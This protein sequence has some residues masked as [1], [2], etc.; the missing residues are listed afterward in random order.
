MN[1]FDINVLLFPSLLIFLS[2]FWVS[3][4]VTGSIA[5]ASAISLLKAGMF[6]AYFGYFFDGTYT[7]LDDWSYLEGGGWLRSQGVGVTNLADNWGFVLMV[8][9]GE[10]FVYYLYNAYAITLFGDGYYAPVALNVIATVFIAWGGALLARREFNFGK[11]GVA[12]FLASL[13]FNP[14]FWLGRTS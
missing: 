6:L 2:A 8:G 13:S 5:A 12:L 14:I 7:F 10:H 9:Q 3:H 11:R 1:A 4:R